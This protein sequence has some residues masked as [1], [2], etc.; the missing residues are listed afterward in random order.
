LVKPSKGPA[1]GK[2]QSG[3]EKL[4]DFAT[5]QPMCQH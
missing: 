2:R 1:C 4:W 5:K 3:T